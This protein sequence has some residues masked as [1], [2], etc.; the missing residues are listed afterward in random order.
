MRF[1][2]LLPDVHTTWTKVCIVRGDL[3]TGTVR[4]ALASDFRRPRHSIVFGV[5]GTRGRGLEPPVD[6]GTIYRTVT[7]GV[8]LP[9]PAISI[10][11][12]ESSEGAASGTTRL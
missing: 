9:R 3:M 11:R 5:T 6:P 4:P 10:A 7:S 12:G 2:K 8:L 1:R